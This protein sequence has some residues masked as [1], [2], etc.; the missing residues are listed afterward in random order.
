MPKILP[1]QIEAAANV[2]QQVHIEE[3]TLADGVTVLLNEHLLNVNSARDFINGYKK[4]MLGD[5]YKRALSA[6]AVDCF[7]TQIHAI[8]GYESYTTAVDAVNKHIDYYEKQKEKVNKKGTLHKLR[9][10]VA[11]HT[12][13]I[14][15]K[16][17][18]R[19]IQQFNEG[20]K[21]SLDDS[22]ENRNLRLRNAPKTPIKTTVTTTVFRRNYDVVATVL[23]RAAGKCE[24]CKCDAPFIKSADQQPYLE[25]HHRVPLSQGGHD[26]V[27]NAMALCPNCHRQRHFG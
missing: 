13:K 6:P 20:V 3:I 4:M 16:E 23:I 27:D 24:G 1:S 11:R 12:M 10:V 22:V 17:L 9:D 14:V 18:D 5:V 21:R 26:T 7:L 2:A 15:P 25:V 19:V 8:Y